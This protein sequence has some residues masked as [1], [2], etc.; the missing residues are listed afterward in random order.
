[1]NNKIVSIIMPCHNGAAYIEKAIESVIAQTYND[2]ELIIIDD[3]STDDSVVIVEKYACKDS[4][5]HC[6]KNMNNTGM[7]AS[8]RNAGINEAK[9]RYIAFLDCDDFWISSK[10]QN[11]LPL[12]ENESCAVVYSYYQ[13]IDAR[14]NIISKPIESPKSV[15]YKELLNG[16]CI[17]NLTGVYDTKKV[18]KVFQ[19]EIH[20]EDYLMWLE[21]LSKGYIAMNT[22]SVEGY[23]RVTSSSTSSNKIKSALWN[24]NIY[25]KE[26]KLSFIEA[27]HHF[28]MYS[29][30][31]V[32]KFLM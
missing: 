12:F 29:M 2:W 32:F 24:W 9:G 3:N 1:M 14:G 31:G 13:K 26:L 19:K 17:G 4:R 30:K 23:Y 21:I 11:Q 16:D 8:P 28:T 25:R 15:S 5:I 6:Y 10:L 7:P 27:L 20:A 18:G 22:N